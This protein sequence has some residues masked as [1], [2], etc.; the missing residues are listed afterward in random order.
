[1]T[2]IESLRASD[3]AGDATGGAAPAR[4]EEQQLTGQNR[5]LQEELRMLR[6]QRDSAAASL[7][8]SMTEL[9]GLRGADREAAANHQ[10]FC[11][12]HHGAAHST[13]P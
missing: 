12:A 8:A 4:Q 13:L 5:Q 6:E 3:S 1:M 11:H 2:V 10:V 7:A 9:Q